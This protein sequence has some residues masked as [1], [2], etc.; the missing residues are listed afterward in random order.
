MNVVQLQHVYYC[1][2]QYGLHEGKSVSPEWVADYMQWVYSTLHQSKIGALPYAF[3]TSSNTTD[4][5]FK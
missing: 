3:S 5:L 1:F 4:F 2:I